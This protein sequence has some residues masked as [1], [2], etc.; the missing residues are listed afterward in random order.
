MFCG[1]I[2]I[3]NCQELSSICLCFLRVKSSLYISSFRTLTPPFS[4]LTSGDY[5]EKASGD[6]DIH[7]TNSKASFGFLNISWRS[8]TNCCYLECAPC[9]WKERKQLTEHDVS[10][11]ALS[12][13]WWIWRCNS[14][15]GQVQRKKTITS[16][17][18]VCPVFVY[19]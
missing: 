17:I 15:G 13:F 9:M 8:E 18:V 5:L 10:Q 11:H 1:H 16:H 2:I 3:P 4:Q 19:T 7:Q 12:G 6:I 14:K